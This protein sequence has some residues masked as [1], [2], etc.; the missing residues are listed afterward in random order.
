[1]NTS[2]DRNHH[3]P[4]QSDTRTI[5]QIEGLKIS[6][7][8]SLKLFYFNA[9]SLREKLNELEV[10][11]NE[12]PCRMDV[13]MITET[14]SRN[15]IEA[16]MSLLNYHC[17]FA[18]RSSR[19][20]G[21]SAVFVH[22]DINATLVES[23]CDEYNSIVSVEIGY[24]HKIALA[25]IYRPPQTLATAVDGF[26]ELL[27]DFL[28][29]QGSSTMILCG[30]FNIDLL[31]NNT[32]V[33]KYT[34]TILSNGFNFCNITPTRYEACLDHIITNN[35]AI[36]AAVQ[37]LQY[38]LFDHDAIF[39]E[40]NY[41]IT[42][43]LP[44]MSEIHPKININSFREILQRRPVVSSQS[45]DVETNYTSFISRIQQAQKD[46]SRPIPATTASRRHSKPWMDHEV[47]LC[48][49]TKNYWYAKHRKNRSDE[50]IRSVY[51]DWC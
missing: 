14:W 46:S 29:R 37:H 30:D 35:S 13:L 23:Y 28:T 11:L 17:F 38:S 7:A 3:L 50:F 31:R 10:L 39:V 27:D 22:K 32:T 47:V 18:S 42:T 12:A 2:N 41:T 8:N 9:R 51:C 20:G 21:G 1:M 16:S 24:P 44:Q 34:N 33:Q 48:I 49:R 36:E 15:D 6:K 5:T 43:S 26:L 19:R 40:A 4:S 25:C 45:I